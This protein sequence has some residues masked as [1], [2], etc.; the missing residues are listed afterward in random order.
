VSPKVSGLEKAWNWECLAPRKLKD[1]IMNG[2]VLAKDGIRSD[3]FLWKVRHVSPTR[4]CLT[5]MIHGHFCC[6]RRSDPLRLRVKCRSY[7][8]RRKEHMAEDGSLW[9]MA[10]STDKDDLVLF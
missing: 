1:R 7:L 4:M 8:V 6:N 3:Q 9:L 2:D 10:Y 5:R